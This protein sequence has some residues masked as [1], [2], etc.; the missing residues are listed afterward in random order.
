[1]QL[2]RF[3][4]IA[5]LQDWKALLIMGLIFHTWWGVLNLISVTTPGSSKGMGCWECWECLHLWDPAQQH[6]RD[7]KLGRCTEEPEDRDLTVTSFYPADILP[8]VVCLSVTAQKTVF[9]AVRMPFPPLSS[10]LVGIELHVKKGTICVVSWS[11]KLLDS[12]ST[13]FERVAQAK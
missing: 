1:M 2:R 8:P 7:W 9:L 5:R 4:G 12:C 3:P 11:P 6:Q 13:F 10:R